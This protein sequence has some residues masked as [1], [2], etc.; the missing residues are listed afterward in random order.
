MRRARPNRRKAPRRELPKL[1]ALPRPGINWRALFGLGA[2]A[3]VAWLA[4]ELGRDL[5]E[6]P[7]TKLEIEGS[8]KRVT[9]LDIE[10]AAEVLGEGFLSLDLNE[11][12]ERI[13]KLAWVDRVSL[14]R[15]WPDTLRIRYTEHRAAASWGETGLLNTRGELFAEDAGREYRELPKLVGP[16][17]SHRRVAARYLDVS[18]RL[19]GTSLRLES[20]RMDARGAFSIELAGGLSVRIGREDVDSRIARFFDVALPGLGAELDRAAYVDMRYPNGFAVGWLD[21]PA[22]TPE[23]ARLDSRG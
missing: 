7:V 17:G 11:V 3:G 22:A 1:P 10:A 5:L 15:V 14:Q 16:A 12:R 20:I 2:A 13:S 9:E 4:I 18:E 8:L 19:A 6:L 23:L 21:E